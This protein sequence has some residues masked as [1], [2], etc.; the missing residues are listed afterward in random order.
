MTESRIAWRRA[1]RGVMLIGFGVFFFLSTQD[2]LHHGFWMDALSLWPVC[3]IALGIRLIFQSSKMPAAV[4]LSPLLIMA[5]LSWVAWRG[6]DQPNRSWQDVRVQCPDSV[7]A[8]TLRARMGLVNLNVGTRPLEE[9]LLLQGRR[10]PADRG[11]ISVSDRG[12][13]ARVTLRSHRRSWNGVTLFPG[14]RNRW[15]IDIAED[16]PVRF[17]LEVAF[18]G[19]ELD[20]TSVDVERIDIDGA[21]NDLTFVLGEVEADV[22]IDLEGAFNH[23]ELVVPE[24]TPVRVSTDG[25]INLVDRRSNAKRLTGPGYRVRSDGAFNRIVIRSE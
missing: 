8:W 1:S 2:V 13:S 14:K 18:A 16:L 17:E 3:L 6:D 11:G 24:E 5:T 15:D 22:R 19:G 12:G 25:F 4:L 10:S 7:E 23:L 9:G 20:L 21:L